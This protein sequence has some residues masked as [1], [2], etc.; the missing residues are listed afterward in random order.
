LI[1]SIQLS[2]GA[3]IFLETVANTDVA[4][5]GLWQLSGS[6]DEGDREAGYSHFLEHMLFKGTAKR[7]AFQIAQ[8]VERVGGYLN[9]F[10]EKEV[11]C[12]YCTLPGDNI[13]LAVDVL[14][15]M[16]F[17]SLL[18][19]EEIEKEKAVIVNEIKTVEDNPEEKGQQIY[20][21]SLWKTHP[22]SRK[23]TGEV[24]QVEQIDKHGLQSFYRGRYS[25]SM[26]VIT[27]SGKI[28]S[29]RLL[30]GLTAAFGTD[31]RGRASAG[32]AAPMAGCSR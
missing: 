15:D 4:S 1:Q 22:L 17:S 6:R 5:I 21:E 12:F 27:A 16:Y 18:D 11:T 26:T 7:S 24:Q 30:A 2:S 28:D 8:A 9:A 3:R 32:F 31:G 25:P 20:L 14:T 29:E 13:D 19:E 23:I 10:T